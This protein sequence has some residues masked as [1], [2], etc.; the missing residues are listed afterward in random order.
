MTEKEKE[1]FRL[2]ELTR[3]HI[4][5]QKEIYH[6][7]HLEIDGKGSAIFPRIERMRRTMEKIV[8]NP[9]KEEVE[10]ELMKLAAMCFVHVDE[11]KKAANG[12][13]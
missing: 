13:S 7:S 12:S 6:E 11:V 2:S 5:L 1:Y 8:G 10:K 9:N 4:D 3:R